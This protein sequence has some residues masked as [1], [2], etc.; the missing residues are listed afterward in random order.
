MSFNKNMLTVS[1]AQVLLGKLGLYLWHAL[2]N[3]EITWN[4]PTWK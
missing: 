2:E 4:M 1:K 3:F